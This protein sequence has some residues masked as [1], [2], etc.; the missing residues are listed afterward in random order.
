MTMQIKEIILYNKDGEVRKLPFRTGQVNIITGKSNTGKSAI[1]QIVDYCLGRSSFNIPEGVIRDTVTWYGVVYQISNNQVLVAK[2]APPEDQISQS[3]VYLEVGTVINIPKYSILK[4]NSTDDAVKEQLTRSIGIAPNINIPGEGETREP[5]EATIIHTSYY[6]YQPQSIIANKDILF[7]RQQE[8]YIPQ[9]IKDTIPYFLGAI[10]EDYLKVQHEY[11]VARKNLRIARQNLQEAE[12]IAS[13]KS[14]RGLMLLNEAQQVGLINNEYSPENIEAT[15]SALNGTLDW[16]PTILPSE[17]G[18]RLTRLQEVL[19]T[20]L[21]RF[22]NLHHQIEVTKLYLNETVGYSTESTEQIIRLEP[23]NL[24]DENNQNTEICPLCHTRMDTPIPEIKAIKTSLEKLEKELKNVEGDKPRLEKYI[25]L[26]VDDQENIRAQINETRLEI[27]SILKEQKVAEQL[28][29]TNSRIARVVG[30]ISLFLET[31]SQIDEHSA[32][33]MKFDEAM[34]EVKRYERILDSSEKEDNLESIMRNIDAQMST[35]ASELNLEHST[36][37]YGLDLKQLT[38][39]A[40]RPER[41]IPM[42]RM[43]GGENWLGCHLIS[44]LGLHKYFIEHKRPV[45]NFLFLDQPTQV[46]FPES[47]YKGLTGIPDELKDADLEAVNRMFEY[48]FN[49]CE[50]LTPN[51]QII[52]T[53][54]ANLG[55]NQ[56]KN[57]LIEEPWTEDKALIPSHWIEKQS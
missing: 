28:R 29:D 25:Q 45:P 22:H 34:S 32:L 27:D 39:I 1:I 10:R 54:H 53:E 26:L 9:A 38:A 5:L 36:F 35:W 33:Q 52:I 42:Y 50:E 3:L 31:V 13:E 30:R 44:L 8:T 51:L 41:P 12:Q 46:Y 16:K 37:P 57:A 18:D 11:S 47:L 6:L 14:T 24:F 49:V 17:G 20:Q 4:P 21:T 48:I 43:G 19:N 15:F 2:P 56:Y 7:Y 23:I 55:T 40:Y